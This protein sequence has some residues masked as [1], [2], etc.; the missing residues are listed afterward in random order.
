VLGLFAFAV[1]A[2]WQV[3]WHARAA[4]AAAGDAL[5]F[6]DARLDAVEGELSRLAL[7]LASE[8][9]GCP[10]AVT[11]ELLQASLD[12]NLVRRFSVRTR[13]GAMLCGPAGWS[14]LPAAVS[15]PAPA[16]RLTLAGGP[17]RVLWAARAGADGRLWVAELDPRVFDAEGDGAPTKGPSGLSLSLRSAQGALLVPLGRAAGQPGDALLPDALAI[18]HSLDH[19][20]AVRAM[21]PG[22]DVGADALRQG[23]A[24]AALALAALALTGAAVWYRALLR[25]RLMHRIATGLRKRQFEPYVQP[26]VDLASGQCIGGEILMRWEHP[27]RGTVPPGEFIDAAERSGLIAGM[28]DLVMRRAAHRLA[29]VAQAYPGTVF[30]FNV[31]PSQLR[32]RHFADRLAEIFGSDTLPRQQVMLE[33]TEREA[34]DP[35]SLRALQALRQAGWQ[36]AVDDFG[37]GQSNL[38]SLEKLPIDRIKIDISFVRG[39]DAH[40]ER[41]PVL[42]AIVKLGHDLQVRLIAEGVETQ[43]QWNYLAA[44]GVQAAQ[45]FLI[46]RPMPLKAFTR[47]LADR[48]AGLPATAADDARAEAVGADTERLWQRLRSP[49][50]LDV[51]T[52][53]FRLRAYRDCF[54]GREAVDWL[55]R[56]ERMDRDQ[57]LRTGRRLLA[58]GLIRH[59]VDEHDFEDD[60][61][62]YRLTDPGQPTQAAPAAADEYR[63]HIR[64]IDGPLARDHVRGWLLHRQCCT[65]RDIVDWTVTAYRVSR[66]TAA[67]W[68]ADLMRQGALRHIYDDKPFSDSPALYRLH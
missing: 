25:V 23:L 42:D 2:G 14:P 59:V 39:I 7:R 64:G 21:S 49:G 48:T 20:V 37:T 29:A 13:P 50:G 67:S 52:R 31:A 22:A 28:S 62:F 24:T 4:D 33:L 9:D 8:H 56:H 15:A 27:D 6:I 40:S 61:L 18:A 60:D 68:A 10:P 55:V 65:G 30:T 57:A 19:A 38:A 46:A 63:A 5:A 11:T 43:A 34:V 12:S 35:R 26:V 58:L 53:S 16:R 47:W 45:G 17:G 41:R 3:R 51:R 1:G 32:D 36:I 44:R 66:A 54:V